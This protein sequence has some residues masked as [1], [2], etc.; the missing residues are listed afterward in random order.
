MT[1]VC[2][3]PQVVKLGLASEEARSEDDSG[4]ASQQLLAN[5]SMTP[6]ATPGVFRTPRT[7]AHE[8]TILQEAQNIIALQNVQTPLKGGEN[9]P[10]HET[11]FEGVTPRK[12][13][14]QTPNVVLG[15]PFRTPSQA[16]PGSTPKQLMQ[17]PHSGGGT[18]AFGGMTPG[19]TPVRDQLSINPDDALSEG[20]ESMKS[21]KQ[22]QLEIR[23]QLRAGLSSLPAPRNDFEIVV[24]E[25]ESATLEAMMDHDAGFVEDAAEI[26]ERRARKRREEGGLASQ[27][28]LTY[29]TR[30][31]RTCTCTNDSRRNL[32]WDSFS[33]HGRVLLCSRCS[34]CVTAS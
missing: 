34:A 14:V 23:S 22:Q 9:V 3:L 13:T 18:P 5:Y 12:Q 4:S 16:G 20:F 25:E 28:G 24:P 31:A 29:G 33:L 15:T 27:E 30:C 21:A 26:D 8:D 1:P 19:Q 7:P 2:C 17:S 10:L 11:S 6:G 32:W